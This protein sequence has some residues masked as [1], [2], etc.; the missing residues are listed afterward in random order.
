MKAFGKAM[1]SVGVWKEC[2]MMR[3]S[4]RFYCGAKVQIKYRM[5]GKILKT[6][7]ML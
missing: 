1:P 3:N 6:L 4:V 2:I 5:E 7:E